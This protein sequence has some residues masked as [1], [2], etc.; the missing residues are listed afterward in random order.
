MLFFS[1]TLSGQEIRPEIKTIVQ[2][3]E[4]FNVVHSQQVG[5][6]GRTTEIY[7]LFE[8]LRDEATIEELLELIAYNNSAV[9]TYASWALLDNRYPYLS[10]ICFHFIKNR[11]AVVTYYGCRVSEREISKGLYYRL[12]NQKTNS[13]YSENDSL[14]FQIQ[15]DRIDSIILYSNIETNLKYEAFINNKGNPTTYNRIRE[16]AADPNNLPALVALAEYKD[17]DDIQFLMDQGTNSFLAISV[18]PD[19]AFWNFLLSYKSSER[20]YDYFLAV[21]SFKNESALEVLTDIYQTCDSIQ[22]NYLDEALIKNY[23]S[24]YQNLILKIWEDHKIIDFTVTHKLSNDCPE[25]AYKSFASGLL[26][27]RAINLLQFNQYHRTD[28]LIF[29]MLQTISQHDEDLLLSIC[30]KNVLTA[31]SVDLI[32]F[33]EVINTKQ[34]SQS[35]PNMLYRL[36]GNN[37]ALEIFHICKTLLSFK[38]RDT[39]IELQEILKDKQKFWDWGN[40]SESFRNLFKAHALE[41]EGV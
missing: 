31:K 35:I 11:D 28:E 9:K 33:I 21:C 27:D 38:N 4:Q 6:A 1:Y 8:E 18:F 5:P 14:Y 30:N 37:Q 16:L 23:C 10:N 13:N 26:L 34:F 40:W 22:I 2:K 15:L 39:N 41:I 7:K 12:L 29:L 25:N 19:S 17:K 32:P 36:R 24:L 3:L 20:S